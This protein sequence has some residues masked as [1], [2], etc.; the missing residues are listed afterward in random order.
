MPRGIEIHEWLRRLRRRV[1]PKIDPPPM[2]V[3]RFVFDETL[4]R[5]IE[6]SVSIAGP[7]ALYLEWINPF[8][9]FNWVERIVARHTRSSNF[10]GWAIWIAGN[11]EFRVR[12]EATDPKYYSFRG[13]DSAF[14]ISRV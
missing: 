10:V 12:A 13:G 7:Q 1:R 5:L 4:G 6:V 11:R 14:E 9:S 3:R 8:A 2:A